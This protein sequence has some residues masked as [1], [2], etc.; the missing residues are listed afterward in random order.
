MWL[1]FGSG[2]RLFMQSRGTYFTCGATSCQAYAIIRWWHVAEISDEFLQKFTRFIIGG[3][4]QYLVAACC[5]WFDGD[6]RDDFALLLS[7]QRHAG[8]CLAMIKIYFLST[9]SITP[10]FCRSLLTFMIFCCCNSMNLWLLGCDYLSVDDHLQYHN[11]YRQNLT[12][13]PERVSWMV[14]WWRGLMDKFCW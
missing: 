11:Y 7:S 5:S 13:R 3:D 8:S 6:R 14:G 4:Y 10:S 1:I 12:F 9:L 2:R